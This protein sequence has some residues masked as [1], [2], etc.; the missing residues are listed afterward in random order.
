M[1]E[2]FYYK[3]VFYIFMCLQFGFVIFDKRKLTKKLLVKCWKLIS[4][5]PKK[6]EKLE[7]KCWWIWL[8]MSISPTF[9]ARVFCM[10]VRS[11]PKHNSKN[12]DEIDSWCQFHQHFMNSFFAHFLGQKNYKVKLKLDKSFERHFHLK[13][14]KILVKLTAKCEKNVFCM[15]LQF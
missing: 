14:F 13:K 10:K 15:N 2:L 12:V 5:S 3:S 7:V 8:L 6:L 1:Y 4:I 9:Y 11:K